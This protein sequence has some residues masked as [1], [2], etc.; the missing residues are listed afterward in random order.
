[1]FKI[2]CQTIVYNS[3]GNAKENFEMIADSVSKIGYDGIEVGGG[4]FDMDKPEYYIEYF[5]K[6]NLNPISY[7][8]GGDLLDKEKSEET[9]ENI[10]KNVEFAK[11]IG[12]KYVFISGTNKEDVT[13]DE[14]KNQAK[15]LNEIGKI[16]REK[17]LIFCYHNHHWE[18]FNDDM[19]MNIIL[20]ET[21]EENVKLVPDVGWVTRGGHNPVE[22]IDENLSR[23]AAVHFKE[24]TTDD[25]FSELGTGIVDFKGVYEYLKNKFDDFW[26]VAEQDET[27]IGAE[28]SAEI[29]YNYIK[30]LLS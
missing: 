28:K 27:K 18:F 15:C 3:L 10:L 30:N 2:A 26:I 8:V 17:G 24:F 23:I 29:N 13:E 1:M 6:K 9:K 5:K 25:G 19:G 12:S 20:N 11:I 21:D 22:F 16:C 14:Y 7:H 4:M